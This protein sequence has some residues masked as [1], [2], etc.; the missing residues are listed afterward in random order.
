MQKQGLTSREMRYLQHQFK[1]ANQQQRL[2]LQEQIDNLI[3]L[4][5]KMKNVIKTN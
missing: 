5:G 2:K 4:E 1:H 3:E